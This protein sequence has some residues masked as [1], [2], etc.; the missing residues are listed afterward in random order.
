MNSAGQTALSTISS[1]EQEPGNV[2]IKVVIADDEPLARQ[3]LVHLVR[4][5][6]GLSIVGVAENGAVAERMIVESQPDLVFLDIKMPRMGGVELTESL[7]GSKRV[8]LIVF[9]TAFN[10]FAPDAFD[11]DVLDYLVKPV[12]KERFARAVDRARRAIRSRRVQALGEQIAAV[13]ASDAERVEEDDPYVVIKQRDE[14]VRVLESDIF[15]LEAASQYVNIHTRDESFVV[16]EPMKKYFSRLTL[17]DFRR[18]HRSAVVNVSKVQR[19]L[20]RPNGVHELE[21]I[22]GIGVPLSRSRKALVRELLDTCIG[23]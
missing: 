4:A 1:D 3:L 13:A 17:P 11:L 23:R 8:P 2:D 7:R 14:L 9:V 22:N 12:A 20:K 21:L 6:P 16:A 15:W 19:I 18:V 10:R 5:Q